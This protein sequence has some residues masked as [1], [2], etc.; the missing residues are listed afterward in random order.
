ML[1]LLIVLG[2]FAVLVPIAI[3]RGYVLSILWAWFMVP[4]FG[5]P[6]LSL[7]AAIGVAMVI[8]FLTYQHSNCQEKEQ[9]FGDKLTNTFGVAFIYPLLSLGMGW[10]VLQFM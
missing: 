5:L 6:A 10:V 3:W 8:S 9:S 2:T 7:A 1:P 4:T